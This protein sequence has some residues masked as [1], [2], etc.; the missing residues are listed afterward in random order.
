MVLVSMRIM[1]WLNWQDE[2]IVKLNQSAPPGYFPLSISILNI[3]TQP[4]PVIFI[5]P[6]PDIFTQPN[7]DI[8]ICSDSPFPFQLSSFSLIIFTYLGSPKT[9]KIG[10]YLSSSYTEKEPFSLSDAFYPKVSAHVSISLLKCHS[11]FVS[12]FLLS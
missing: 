10:I 2:P 8:L 3:F 6:N 12:Q 11:F 7:P 5:P 1:V 4:T 9:D